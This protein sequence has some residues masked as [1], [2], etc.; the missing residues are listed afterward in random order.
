[1]E[2]LQL[3]PLHQTVLFELN[4]KKMSNRHFL[5]IFKRHQFKIFVSSGM[6]LVEVLL[7]S[8]FSFLVIGGAT[9]GLMEMMD[10]NTKHETRSQRRA[11]LDRAINFIAKN[12][13]G[14]NTIETVPSSATLPGSNSVGLFKLTHPHIDDDFDNDPLDIEDDDGVPGTDPTDIVYFIAPYNGQTWL[15][16]SIVY[17]ARGDYSGG[18]NIPTRSSPGVNELIDGIDSDN[19]SPPTCDSGALVG[20]NS[21]RP[22][23][24]G[25]Y[26]CIIDNNGDGNPEE[27]ELY[28]YGKVDYA[29]NYNQ[30]PFLV[31]TKVAKRLSP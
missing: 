15:P 1:M 22:D 13:R 31:R 18:I 4:K 23:G 28:L 25:F 11:E 29:N 20:T 7:A 16:P 14:A 24:L 3:V 2:T 5:S 26:A 17:Q 27:I 30:E 12:I 21:S 10:N 8:S 9:Y 6:T 19:T